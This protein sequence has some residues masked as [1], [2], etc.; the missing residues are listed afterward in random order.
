MQSDLSVMISPEMYEEFIIPELNQQLK[1]LEY[2]TYHF[3]GVEQIRHLD[4]L[5]QLEFDRKSLF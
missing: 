2:S 1:W 3:D 4:K 5:L